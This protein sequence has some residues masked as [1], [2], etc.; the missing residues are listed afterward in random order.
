[1]PRWKRGHEGGNYCGYLPFLQ[2]LV[3]KLRL[4]FALLEYHLHARVL[5]QHSQVRAQ[6]VVE[7][8]EDTGEAA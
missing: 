8:H 2:R 5:E 1:M 6:G 7:G 4:D 3:Q